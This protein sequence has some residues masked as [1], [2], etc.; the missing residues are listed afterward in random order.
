MTQEGTIFISHS[1]K[2]E[3][4]VSAFVDK[5]LTVGWE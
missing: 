4:I 1:S 2:D 3:Q 5:I